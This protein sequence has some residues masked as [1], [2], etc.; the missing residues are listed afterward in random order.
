MRPAAASGAWLVLKTADSVVY[1][2]IIK[3]STEA[4]FALLYEF[5]YSNSAD[6]VSSRYKRS[7][8]V[9]MGAQS[10]PDVQVIAPASTRAPI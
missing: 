8:L 7:R 4:F 1:M 5:S 10:E 9:E 3:L 6:P 2:P